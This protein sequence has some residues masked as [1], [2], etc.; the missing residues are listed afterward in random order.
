M[1]PGTRTLLDGERYIEMVAPLPAEGGSLTLR[2]RLVGVH[3]K[4]KGALLTTES[5]LRDG[6]GALLYRL[7]AGAY[8]VGAAGFRDEGRTLAAAAPAPARA[9][10]C[11]HEERVGDGQA[12]L[13][14]LSGDYNP[15]HVDPTVAG[16]SGFGAPILHGLCTLGFATRAVLERCAAGEPARFRSV[17]ARF[18]G[19]VAPGDTLRTSMWLDG[20]RVAFV[21]DAT[22]AGG[23]PKRV[24]AN[25]C[26][27]LVGEAA[28]SSPAS[29]L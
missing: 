11:V 10:D 16:L 22:P 21:T 15:L 12:Q 4:G 19:T 14:R 27:E 23:A 17:R 13:Y 29:K 2:S 8:A 7:H 1:L 20:A 24:V 9:P 28:L 18:V 5:E 6:S 3:A 26:V 25:A